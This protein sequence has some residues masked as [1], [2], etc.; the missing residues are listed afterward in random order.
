M[1][2]QGIKEH[3]GPIYDSANIG[4]KAPSMVI[5][6]LFTLDAKAGLPYGIS[7]CIL[8]P[9]SI[10][11]CL[12]AWGLLWC[13]LA[14]GSLGAL[15]RGFLLVVLAT[16]KRAVPNFRKPMWRNCT[17]GARVLCGTTHG[18]LERLPCMRPQ[19]LNLKTWIWLARHALSFQGSIHM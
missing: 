13:R 7:G 18:K 15:M 17:D 8:C 3:S 6:H 12:R 16:S 5:W 9:T 14:G 4:S 11:F 1:A 19:D 10:F 2:K